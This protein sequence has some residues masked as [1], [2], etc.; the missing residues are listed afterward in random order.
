MGGAEAEGEEEFSEQRRRL[1]SG[2]GK[3]AGR[4]VAR[5][6][7]TASR[8]RVRFLR[9]FRDSVG[10]PPVSLALPCSPST[11]G[12]CDPTQSVTSLARHGA[13]CRPLFD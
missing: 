10:M 6:S 5:V 12:A 13:P 8:T 1:R 2:V 4:G 11:S 9:A 7:R 3:G